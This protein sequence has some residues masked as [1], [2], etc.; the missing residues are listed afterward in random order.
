M[1]SH[2]GMYWRGIRE[3]LRS[4][5]FFR[6][7]LTKGTFY[8]YSK[9]FYFIVSK[10]CF[11]IYF[12]FQNKFVLISIRFAAN[13]SI[14]CCLCFPSCVVAKFAVA[15]VSQTIRFEISSDRPPTLLFSNTPLIIPVSTVTSQLLCH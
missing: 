15:H 12:F 9:L 14:I 1:L 4:L 13:S 2:P 10:R 3:D 5:T 11:Q 6:K 8:L 7:R